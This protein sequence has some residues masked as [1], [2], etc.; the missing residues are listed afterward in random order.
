M[1][2]RENPLFLEALERQQGYCYYCDQDLCCTYSSFSAAELDSPSVQSQSPRVCCADCAQVLAN[3]PGEWPID[4][5]Q[6]QIDLAAARGA[7]LYR[8]A[9]ERL[10]PSASGRPSL[11]IRL[12]RSKY[13]A[14]GEVISLDHMLPR[15]MYHQGGVAEFDAVVDVSAGEATDLIYCLDGSRWSLGSLTMKLFSERR[16]SARFRKS[17]VSWGVNPRVHWTTS[18][19]VCLE[20]L[21]VRMDWGDSP[22]DF[23]HERKPAVQS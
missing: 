15:F 6:Q 3:C 8:T 19:G 16:R 13:L 18:A 10:R 21:M 7:D 1:A 22:V 14:N 9:L 23:N 4:Q 20:A 12:V 17:S 2:S 11:L 5:R